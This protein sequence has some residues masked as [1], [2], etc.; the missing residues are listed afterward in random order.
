MASSN[1]GAVR[2]TLHIANI[3]L[4]ATAVVAKEK[5]CQKSDKKG[6][7]SERRERPVFKYGRPESVKKGKANTCCLEVQPTQRSKVLQSVTDL[8]RRPARGLLMRIE[9]N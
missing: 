2:T 1:H 5:S 9:G 3:L 6:D 4:N 8:S 7:L